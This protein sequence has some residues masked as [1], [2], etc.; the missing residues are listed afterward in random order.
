MTSR[1]PPPPPILNTDRSRSRHSRHDLDSARARS[2]S[3]A[4]HRSSASGRFHDERDRPGRRPRSRSP[5][6][7]DRKSSSS[8]LPPNDMLPP[9]TPVGFGLDSK[10]HHSSPSVSRVTSISDRET[11]VRRILT[12]ENVAIPRRSGEG[13]R[14]I[15][16]RDELRESMQRRVRAGDNDVNPPLQEQRVVAIIREP[17]LGDQ[18][19]PSRSMQQQQQPVLLIAGGRPEIP[20]RQTT[21]TGM[22]YRLKPNDPTG[23]TSAGRSRSVEKPVFDR[24]RERDRPNRPIRG[25]DP[26]DRKSPKPRGVPRAR[27]EN[28][29]K[30]RRRTRSR[31]VTPPPMPPE[32][33]R[34]LVSRNVGGRNRG[35]FGDRRFEGEHDSRESNFRGRGG[36]GSRRGRG[37]TFPSRGFSSRARGRSPGNWEHDMYDRERVGDEP[38][39]SKRNTS[40]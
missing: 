15:F 35:G 25:S 1:N 36:R 13:A 16:D 8:K 39:D 28:R 27:P 32:M 24:D 10:L 9:L 34:N 29:E 22:S 6:T 20:D 38:S 33:Q 30:L 37:T 12:P 18:Y 26:F 23:Y 31:S 3:P 11:I 17:M 21:S 40:K 14:P 7:Y 2:R 5:P 19:L 4:H